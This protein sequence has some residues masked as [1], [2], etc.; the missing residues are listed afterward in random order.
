MFKIYRAA[1]ALFAVAA[2]VG[3]TTAADTD[4]AAKKTAKNLRANERKLN[5]RECP[6]A[7]VIVEG[8]TYNCGCA[9]N[10]AGATIEGV[11]PGD[12]PKVCSAFPG[13][14]PDEPETGEKRHCCCEEPDSDACEED[15]FVRVNPIS[16]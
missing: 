8:V 15:I 12:K 6:G 3:S 7:Q 10:C 2:A 4:S 13:T 9:K 5:P 14:C 11:E 16:F 1:L